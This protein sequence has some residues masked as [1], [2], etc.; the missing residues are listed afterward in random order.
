MGVPLAEG[1]PLR[2]DPSLTEG[3]AGKAAKTKPSK[4]RRA[5]AKA[6]QADGGNKSA[7]TPPA[8]KAKKAKKSEPKERSSSPEP[9]VEAPKAAQSPEDFRKEHAIKVR[10]PAPPARTLHCPAV[11]SFALLSPRDCRDLSPFIYSH[12]AL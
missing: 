1:S 9:A 7:A 8:K 12:L 3:A 2:T 11:T 10:L 6:E 5:A 4:K